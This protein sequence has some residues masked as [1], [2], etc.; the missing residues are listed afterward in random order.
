[1]NK[2][3]HQVFDDSC[4]RQIKRTEDDLDYFKVSKSLN[5]EKNL[6]NVKKTV[7]TFKKGDQVYQYYLK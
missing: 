6:P 5:L 2:N 4:C 7:A 3:S 1:M